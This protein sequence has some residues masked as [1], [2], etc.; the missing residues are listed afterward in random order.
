MLPLLVTLYTAPKYGGEELTLTGDTHVL[1]KKFSGARSLRVC[2]AAA[3][4]GACTAVTAE[5]ECEEILSDAIVKRAQSADTSHHAE[6]FKHAP[7][8]HRVRV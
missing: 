1:P 6:N 8:P 4:G 7:C 3:G 5:P 2:V